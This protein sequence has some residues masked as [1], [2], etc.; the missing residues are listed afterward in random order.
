MKILDRVKASIVRRLSLTSPEGWQS[1]GQTAD[2]GE[3]VTESS[4][5]ALSAVWAC[6]NLLS[7]TVSSLP[8][9]V[10]RTK[11]MQSKYFS[12]FWV[13]GIPILWWVALLLLE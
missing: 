1:Q 4:V 6:A 5:M 11:K 2:A 13:E 10:Y 9:M 12:S 7:G 3:I 8:L